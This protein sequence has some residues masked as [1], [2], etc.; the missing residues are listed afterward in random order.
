MC[1]AP[2]TTPNN[3]PVASSSRNPN[4]P[5]AAVGPAT[6]NENQ[7]DLTAVI[8]EALAKWPAKQSELQRSATLKHATPTE[9][10][11]TPAESGPNN[12][13]VFE[14]SDDVLEHL[15]RVA[16]RI[17]KQRKIEELRRL[18]AGKSMHIRGE[19]LNALAEPPPPK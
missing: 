4:G 18:I 9:P 5:H 1:V 15:C 8:P 14:N 10:G 17:R 7:V 12:N 3:E 19:S 6:K 13:P 11:L 2:A 16:E